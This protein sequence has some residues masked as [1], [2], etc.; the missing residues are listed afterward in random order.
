V[1]IREDRDRRGRRPGEVPE[2]IRKG[3]VAEAPGRECLI[4][5]DQRAALE[6]ALADM[7]EGEVIVVFYDD[8]APIEAFI[9]ERGFRPAAY[10][11]SA[12]AA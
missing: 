12:E 7:V 2:L 9:N 4:I 11:R 1:I 5:E 3:V 8:L 6:H 10:G